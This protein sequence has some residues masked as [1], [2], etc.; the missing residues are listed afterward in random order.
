[1][2][3]SYLFIFRS[4][5]RHLTRQQ[6][7]AI[8]LLEPHSSRKSPMS[9]SL[10]YD[11]KMRYSETSCSVQSTPAPAFFLGNS[12]TWAS[13]PYLSCR[14]HQPLT[15]GVCTKGSPFRSKRVAVSVLY[16]QSRSRSTVS[17]T[18]YPSPARGSD[19]FVGKKRAKRRR[20]ADWDQTQTSARG[21]RK[22]HLLYTSDVS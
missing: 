6:D 11:K 20:K 18:L 14:L 13:V 4:H 9:F 8:F 16:P 7:R 15:C 3:I 21:R 12:R 10:K 19:A 5:W 17:I 2:R 1:M 22:P